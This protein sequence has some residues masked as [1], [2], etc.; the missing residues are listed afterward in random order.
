MDSNIDL[1]RVVMLSKL[2]TGAHSSTTGHKRL[3]ISNNLPSCIT[4]IIISGG[5]PC[6]HLLNLA[7]AQKGLD[8][9]FNI[10]W[11]IVSLKK[12]RQRA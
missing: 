11:G 9:R 4:V 5:V 2:E 3:W 7:H 6:K 8:Q 10:K 12:T 1:E